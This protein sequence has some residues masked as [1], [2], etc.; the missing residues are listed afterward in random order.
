[1]GSTREVE[2]N[3]L[4]LGQFSDETYV[5]VEM[6]LKAGDRSVLYTDG[7]PECRNRLEEEFG[8]SRFMRFIEENHGLDVN[9]FADALLGQL[10]GWSEQPQ[11]QGQRDDMTLVAFH[12]KSQ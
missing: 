8:T 10:S 6:P 5:A 1:M 2:E 7:I 3:G 9:E 11:G 12:Y 4:F